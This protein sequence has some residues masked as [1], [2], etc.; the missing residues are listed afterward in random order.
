MERR[1]ADRRQTRGSREGRRC[2]VPSVPLWRFLTWCLRHGV[3]QRRAPLPLVDPSAEDD[4]DHVEHIEA[5]VTCRQR[6]R[7]SSAGVQA[8]GASLTLSWWV[9]GHLRE[10]PNPFL[11]ILGS[12]SLLI[13][14]EKPL[15]QRRKRRWTLP[16]R[17]SEQQ[18]SLVCGP[19]YP[20]A[21][22]TCLWP[23]PFHG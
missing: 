18:A 17:K 23:I 6:G 22:L 8:A 13:S 9:S 12:P 11:A 16:R 20:P 10:S 4:R 2:P 1:Q 14:F 5:Q 15:H 21:G 19:G 3:D 7:P